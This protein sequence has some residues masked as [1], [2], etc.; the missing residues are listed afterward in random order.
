MNGRICKLCGKP[1][2]I[3]RRKHAI[4][5]SSDC[6]HLSLKSRYHSLNPQSTLSP[7]ASGSISEYKVIIDLLIRGFE[8]FRS[9]EPGATCDLA[10]LQNN[11]LL[12][13]EVKTTKYSSIG[14]PYKPQKPIKADIL[15]SVM[16]DRILYTP[17][18]E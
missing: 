11:K 4:Y 10:I 2:P 6:H 12:R 18:L 15:A 1:I 5:C 7:T 3:I 13:V 8:V 17:S 9:V 14:K 16:H